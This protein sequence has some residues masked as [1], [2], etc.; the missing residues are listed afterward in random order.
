MKLILAN[1]AG[2]TLIE[3]LVTLMVL[4]VI[5]VLALPALGTILMN[6]RLKASSDLFVNALNYARSTALSESVTVVVCPLSALNSS[7]CGTHW[8]SGWIVVTQP[9]SGVNTL[10]QSQQSTSTDPTLS[11][12]TTGIFFDP[13]GLSSTQSNFTFCDS[14]GS[15]FAQSV[16]VMVTG[17]IQSGSTPGQAVW[18][19]SML[20]CPS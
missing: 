5:L 1:K 12:T 2:F 4:C 11:G 8:S 17:Y 15:S 10:L 16:V 6:N 7:N 14:R 3:L 13:H 20:S 18:D 19:S 9:A